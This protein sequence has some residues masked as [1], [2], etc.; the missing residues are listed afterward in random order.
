MATSYP[1][2]KHTRRHDNPDEVHEKIVQP[3]VVWLRSAIWPTIDIV[4]EQT[5]GIVQCIAVKMGHTHNQLHGVAQ[6]MPHSS[7]IGHEKAQRTPEKLLFRQS[8]S[9]YSIL[10]QETRGLTTVMLSI[11]RTSVSEVIY[12]ESDRAYS[13]HSCPNRSWAEAMWS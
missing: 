12:R 13:F 7:Q 1:K 6:R 9:N 2:K 10:P 3:K 8:Q 5:S 11:Q 4:I